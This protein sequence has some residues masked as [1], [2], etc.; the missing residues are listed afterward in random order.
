[1]NSNKGDA[2]NRTSSA[3]SDKK[4]PSSMYV[5][6]LLDTSLQSEERHDD[7]DRQQ[8]QLCRV[9]IAHADGLKGPI[10]H[11]SEVNR[12]NTTKTSQISEKGEILQHI[13]DA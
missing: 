6:L 1:M 7:E 11:N 4:D 9:Q 2:S 3:G 10:R 5:M 8:L 12:R 13:G